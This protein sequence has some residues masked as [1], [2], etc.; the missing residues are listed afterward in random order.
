MNDTTSMRHL[1]RRDHVLVLPNAWDSA[2]ARIFERLGAEAIATTSAGFAWANGYGDGHQLPARVLL[3]GIAAI[4]RVTSVP[5]TVD[6]E[7]GYSDDPDE[8][9][10]L[11]RTL[12][13]A[14]RMRGINIEDGD[15]PP[16]SLEKKIRA[17]RRVAEAAKAELFVNARTDVYLNHLVAAHDAL[18]ET[19]ERTRRYQAAGC[20]G[21]FVP[22]ITDAAEITKVVNATD[23]PVNVLA[24]PTL[25]AL[26]E[27]RQIGVRRLSAGST[28][29]LRVYDAAKTLAS[30]FL[31]EGS[32]DGL[33]LSDSLT[34]AYLN[35]WMSET[36]RHGI[37]L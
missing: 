33:F 22:G 5:L 32:T 8:V 1:H 16:E 21:I 12:L 6:L 17:I 37:S 14:T 9:A 18:A 28:I 2:S 29:A 36:S 4:S 35:A 26:D 3:D 31:T 34:Y 30:T 11:V 27:L 19:I 23:L 24:R 15:A 13:E 25:P 10:R 7:A 20:D